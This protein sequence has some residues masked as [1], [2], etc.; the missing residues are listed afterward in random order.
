MRSLQITAFLVAFILIPFVC[1]A[2]QEN[3]NS[4]STVC[5]E[6]YQIGRMIGD[7]IEKGA[8]V[9][10]DGNH[11]GCFKIYQKTAKKILK[12]HG[13]KCPN[14]TLMFGAALAKAKIYDK[15]D[16]D[17]AWTM[18]MAFDNIMGVETQTK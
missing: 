17:R 18:R 15:T 14:V 16:T 2:Q 6:I 11:K 5:F 7:A 12:L 1:S 8:P 13:S 9:Y 10:N 4:G 3:L